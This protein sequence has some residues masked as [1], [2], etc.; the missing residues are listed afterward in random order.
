MYVVQRER[1][2][3]C[4]FSIILWVVRFVFMR[5]A[6]IEEE[7]EKNTSAKAV[8]PSGPIALTELLSTCVEFAYPNRSTERV[9]LV[10]RAEAS[11]VAPE[12][13][14]PLLSSA[15]SSSRIEYAY[16]TTHTLPQRERERE[17]TAMCTVAI[18]IQSRQSGVLA[19]GCSE[20]R[21]ALVAGLSAVHA[22][23]EERFVR[24]E[25]LRDHCRAD[26][27]WDT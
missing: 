16:Y 15:C 1:E 18:E 20:G 23:M 13:V 24:L 11:A 12:S 19:K 21:C 27:T 4:A 6:G 22:E 26:R 2:R 14:I 3:A 9:E 17:S 25:A 10:R 7:G 8:A 5:Y